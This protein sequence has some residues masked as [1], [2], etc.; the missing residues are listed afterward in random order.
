MSIEV[1]LE[2]TAEAKLRQLAEELK[3]PVGEA[4]TRALSNGMFVLAETSAGRNLIVEDS[5]RG[6]QWRVKPS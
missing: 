5:K 6:A 1:K 4:L 2:G 3:V